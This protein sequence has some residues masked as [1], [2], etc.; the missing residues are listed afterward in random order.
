MYLS[1]LAPNLRNL[2]ARRDLANPYEMH[3]TLARAAHSESER[4]LWRLE[5]DEQP[6]LLVQ[7]LSEPDWTFLDPAY[8]R[9]PPKAKAVHLNFAKGQTLR[10]RLRAN[11]TVKRQGKRQALYAIQDQ[12][13]WLKRKAEQASFNILGA[14]AHRQEQLRAKRQGKTV[15]L[16]AVT[17]DG[18]LQVAEPNSFQTALENGIGSAK[19][20]GMGL[21]S[22]APDA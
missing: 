13:E 22:L 2:Q 16:F 18:H 3:R 5:E 12:H 7:T 4:L 11:P 17:F 6:T 15:T 10:F 8:L 19:G 20:F 9:C 21:L 14:M 1:K